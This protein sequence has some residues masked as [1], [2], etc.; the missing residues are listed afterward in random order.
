MSEPTAF[1]D[2]NV[3]VSAIFSDR[4]AASHLIFETKV[5]LFI[6]KQVRKESAEAVRR[7]GITSNN[8]VAAVYH[9]QTTQNVDRIDPFLPYVL[10]KDDAHIVA[11]AVAAEA[12]FLITY[13]LRHYRINKI[14]SELGVIIHT[15]GQFLQ[16]LRSL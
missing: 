16:Y 12:N 7:A 9:L 2:S 6:S 3:V 4:G 14:K 5:P 13:N 10:D 8:L 15:P 11:G 1:I